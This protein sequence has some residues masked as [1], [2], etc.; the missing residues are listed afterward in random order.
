MGV[1]ELSVA[2]LKE[3]KEQKEKARQ[4]RGDEEL[5]YP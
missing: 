5:L 3:L 4:P 2:A 1:R